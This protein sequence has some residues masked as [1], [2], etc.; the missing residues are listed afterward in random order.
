MTCK[1]TSRA[2]AD[3]P[4][5]AECS[6][7]ARHVRVQVARGRSGAAALPLGR[8][9]PI[10]LVLL[11]VSCSDQPKGE[12]QPADWSDERAAMVEQLRDYGI[13]DRGVIEAMK[14]VR[15]HV[16]IPESHRDRST[17]YG[18]HP[19]PNGHGQTGV[20]CQG[21]CPQHPWAIAIILSGRWSP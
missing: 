6:P 2:D 14:K 11:C 19:C 9:V 7:R 4:R 10:L 12:A 20:P 13:R 1:V 18:D 3:R 8:V 21:P 17:A 16:Y 5:R 15:R